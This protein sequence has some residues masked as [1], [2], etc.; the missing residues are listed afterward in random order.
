MK[1][2][3]KM[4]QKETKGK[5]VKFPKELTAEMLA[6][7]KTTPRGC[8]HPREGWIDGGHFIAKCGTWSSYSSGKHVH[9]E[10]VTDGFLR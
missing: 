6:G 5:A 1:G 10:F 9:N 2:K 8:T 7:F 4:K 3:R